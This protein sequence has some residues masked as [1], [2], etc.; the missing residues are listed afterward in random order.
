MRV[1]M[2]CTREYPSVHPDDSLEEAVREMGRYSEYTVVVEDDGTLVGL[3][4][5]LDVANG[6]IRGIGSVVEVSRDPEYVRRDD[7]ITEAVRLLMNSELTL[8][9]VVEEGK[10]IGAVTLRTI[11][12]LMS[13]LYDTPVEDLLRTIQESVP[14]ITWEEFIEAAADVF[15]RQTG[16]NETPEEFESKLKDRTFGY[17]LWLL[18]GIE[19]LFVY[20]FK[21]GETVVA[22]RV[23][24]R[25]REFRGSS[26]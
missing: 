7:P 21:L 19:N 6:L 4:T 11:V 12:K 13:D 23:A 8:L 20:L 22:R 24:K 10:V 16:R 2:W 25:R 1:E 15:N 5:A 9:P 17:V 18:G 26:G 3:A 14:G